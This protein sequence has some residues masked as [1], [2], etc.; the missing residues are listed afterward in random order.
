ML[1]KLALSLTLAQKP[2]TFSNY[3]RYLLQP[4]ANVRSVP[5]PPPP[6]IAPHTCFPKALRAGSVCCSQCYYEL[7]RVCV[8][9][10][11][12]TRSPFIKVYISTHQQHILQH[13]PQHT[14]LLA[15]YTAGCI[16]LRTCMRNVPRI[17]STTY[18]Q[19]THEISKIIYKARYF[20]PLWRHTCC[21]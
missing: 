2:I 17:Y 1:S 9:H 7:Q 20:M 12:H 6:P 14:I 21:S 4:V 3:F 19:N 5:S 16:A 10:R 13:A 11:P 18:K 8:P 15:I